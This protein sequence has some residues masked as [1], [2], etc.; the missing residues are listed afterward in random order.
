[1]SS[2]RI[3]CSGSSPGLSPSHHCSSSGSCARF[4]GSLV[5]QLS[6]RSCVDHAEH[7]QA[8]DHHASLCVPS[9]YPLFT[10]CLGEEFRELRM[11]RVLGSPCAA[12]CPV[13]PY[14]SGRGISLGGV[15]AASTLLTLQRGW[16]FGV[17]RVRSGHSQRGIPQSS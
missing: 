11:R 7:E 5:I 15:P 10:D 12:S 8:A 2:V 16:G 4:N 17:G 6:P 9:S 3:T 1:M 14:L 13:P